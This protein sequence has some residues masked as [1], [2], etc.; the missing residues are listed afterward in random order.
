MKLSEAIRLGAM[1][2]PQRY[3]GLNNGLCALEA[4][5]VG[6]GY[7][8][9]HW[10]ET[11]LIWPWVRNPGECPACNVHQKYHVSVLKWYKIFT[12]LNDTHRWTREKIAAFVEMVEPKE[13]I[14]EADQHHNPDTKLYS[15]CRVA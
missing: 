4:G 2:A 5:L 14:D 8:H 11:S 6:I 12:H 10:A 9:L 7:P 1:T 15:E 3:H 13:C